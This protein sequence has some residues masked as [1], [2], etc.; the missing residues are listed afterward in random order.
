MNPDQILTLALILMV[1][2][3]TVV[4]VPLLI[5]LRNTL[6]KAERLFYRLE[7]EL[8]PAVR[9]LGDT[10]AELTVLSENLN[11][12]LGDLDQIISHARTASDHLADTGA[13]IKRAFGPW[14]IHA[15]TIGI[16]IRTFLEFLG[17]GKK[18]KKE[19]EE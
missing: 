6:K 2:A 15:G 14:V 5:Q 12:R 16:G 18:R 13:M 1:V 7:Q 9:K 4:L 17:H 3:L 11:R 19:R 8:P 10:A